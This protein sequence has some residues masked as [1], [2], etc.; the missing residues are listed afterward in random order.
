[1]YR[2]LADRREPEHADG[3][4]GDAQRDRKAP[5]ESLSSFHLD[6]LLLRNLISSNVTTIQLSLTQVA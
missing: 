2:S 5:V 6:P 4:S 1:V 3:Q